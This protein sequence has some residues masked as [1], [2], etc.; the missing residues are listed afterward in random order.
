M[1]EINCNGEVARYDC[2]ERL[3][4]FNQ[5]KSTEQSINELIQRCFEMYEGISGNKKPEKKMKREMEGLGGM[6]GM[7][8]GMGGMGGRRFPF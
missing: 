4:Y 3:L 6:L 1:L 8:R 2:K 5:K 7:M